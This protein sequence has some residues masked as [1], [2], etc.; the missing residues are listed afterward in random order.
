VTVMTLNMN[1]MEVE[2]Q[3]DDEPLH[4]DEEYVVVAS[5][6]AYAARQTGGRH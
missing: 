5:S 4:Q 6:N 1:M 3:E 2:G